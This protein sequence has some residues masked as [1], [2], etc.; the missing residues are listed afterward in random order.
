MDVNVCQDLSIVYFI[1]VQ[2]IV[3]WLYLNKAALTKMIENIWTNGMKNQ[4]IRWKNPR[5]LAI[6]Q[7]YQDFHYLNSIWAT[8]FFVYF[9]KYLIQAV[10]RLRRD[11]SQCW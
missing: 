4:R 3:C 5:V 11:S 6:F 2:F 7:A 10:R 9:R 8:I 1:H